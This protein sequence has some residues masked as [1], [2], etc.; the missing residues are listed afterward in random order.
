M[1]KFSKPKTVEDASVAEIERIVQ[2]AEAADGR[3]GGGK[4]TANGYGK[5]VR[6]TMTLD[7]EMAEEIDRARKATGR[8]GRLAWLRQAAAEKL[9]RDRR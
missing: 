4:Q 9:A 3:K 8:L 2:G 7:A 5:E 1:S 6:F